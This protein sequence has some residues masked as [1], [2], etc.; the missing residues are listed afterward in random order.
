VRTDTA[1]LTAPAADDPD[2]LL[3]INFIKADLG[4]VSTMTLWRLDHH[5]DPEIRFPEPDLVL[6]SKKK[7]WRN[8]RY[9]E[10]KQRL[11]AKRQINVPRPAKAATVED[12]M[13]TA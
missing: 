7:L 3:D 4:G 6:G 1:I 12:K 11:L 5:P 13:I 10:W 9:R 8:G 2:R